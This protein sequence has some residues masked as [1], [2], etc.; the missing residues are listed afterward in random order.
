[1]RRGIGWGIGVFAGTSLALLTAGVLGAFGSEGGHRTA[2][3]ASVQHA[4]ANIVGPGGIKGRVNFVQTGT[5]PLSP[6]EVTATVQGLPPGKHGMHIHEIGSCVGPTFTSAGGHFD[7]GPNGNS[8]PDGNHPFHAGDLPN[9]DAK[10]SIGLAILVYLHDN[11]FTLDS[12]PSGLF[13]GD[14]SAVIIHA[15]LDQFTTAV[16]GGAGGGRIACGVIQPG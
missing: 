13:D 2:A 6:V 10:G 12:G 4:F 7:P 9:L 15:S 8:S 5:G 11:R 1:M 14:G 3:K 16:P